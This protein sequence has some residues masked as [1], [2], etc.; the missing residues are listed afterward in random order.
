MNDASLKENLRRL[1]VPEPSE[2][3]RGRALHRALIALEQGDSLQDKP[4]RKSLVW[5]WGGVAA[6]LALL[7]VIQITKLNLFLN[8]RGEN[9]NL[10]ANEAKL[11]LLSDNKAVEINERM[12]LLVQKEEDGKR[13][14]ARSLVLGQLSSDAEFQNR[15]RQREVSNGVPKAAL[16]TMMAKGSLGALGGRVSNAGAGVA[17]PPLAINGPMNSYSGGTVI[18]G[19]TVALANAPVSAVTK[20]DVAALTVVASPVPKSETAVVS[21]ADAYVPQAITVETSAKVP[22]PDPIGALVTKL[23]ADGL[24]Q[25][26]A[27]KPIQLPSSASPEEVLAQLNK[28]TNLYHGSKVTSY[29]I[30]ESRQVKII[31]AFQ[32]KNFTAVLLKTNL[33]RKVVLL[34]YQGASVGWWSRVYAVPAPL[35]TPKVSY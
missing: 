19:G 1:R 35:S 18:L 17:A 20:S 3:A 32:D 25:N 29:K 15:L 26:G 10:V 27:F 22:P 31:A 21:L 9:R 24:W 30:I 4:A 23:S 5:L 13:S 16:E 34:K 2:A 14:P 7:A 6:T 28:Q 12:P 8:Y 33:G 11:R